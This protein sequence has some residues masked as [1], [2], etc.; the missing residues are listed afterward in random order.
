MNKCERR[1]VKIEIGKKKLCYSFVPVE[2]TN[3]IKQVFRHDFFFFTIQDWSPTVFPSLF[4]YLSA[5][6]GG[7]GEFFFFFRK[8]CC[9]FF[10]WWFVWFLRCFGCFGF[11][12]SIF[13]TLRLVLFISCVLT[14]R[15]QF[16]K[17]P[18]FNNRKKHT[19]R[20]NTQVN[21]KTLLF[22][23]AS[24]AL[25]CTVFLIVKGGGDVTKEKTP[26]RKHKNKMR[27]RHTRNV[28]KNS[29]VFVLLF[30]LLPLLLLLYTWIVPQLCFFSFRM[31]ASVFFKTL[32]ITRNVK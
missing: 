23:A 13:F 26:Q 6:S 4:F 3:S 31:G 8:R 30:F 17:S 20:E 12:S 2:E 15:Q 19:K 29:G 5:K 32:L 28:V 18:T 11:S 21:C 1:E 14:P 9:L 16:Q 27:E 24:L 10:L 7:V 25:P 22:S